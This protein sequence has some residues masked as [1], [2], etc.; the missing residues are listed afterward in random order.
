M[1]DLR[2]IE[3]HIRQKSFIGAVVKLIEKIKRKR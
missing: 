2:E 1:E 3:V